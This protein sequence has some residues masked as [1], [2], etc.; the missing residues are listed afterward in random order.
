MN[1]SL[2]SKVA[3]V[4]GGGRGIGKAIALGLSEEGANVVV[5]ARTTADIDDTVARIK[6]H[7]GNAVAITGDTRKADDVNR[8]VNETVQHFGQVDILVNNAGIDGSMKQIT[9]ITEQ[10]LTEVLNTNLNG[11][12]LFSEAVLPHM[13]PRHLGNIINISSSAGVKSS[14]L[15][16]RSVTYTISKFA[17]EGLTFAMAAS[18]AGTGVNVNALRPGYVKT[19]LQKSWTSQQLRAH[20]GAYGN[21]RKPEA[22]VPVAVYLASLKPG[23]LSGE[24]ISAKEWYKSKGL[25]W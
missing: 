21:P 4:T 2:A 24:S 22:V 11:P 1:D 5:T 3:I 13:L 7:H 10:E 23:E 8:V 14:I 20:E 16:V 12:F 17:L 6:T 15:R 18:L 9:E 25:E 19:S